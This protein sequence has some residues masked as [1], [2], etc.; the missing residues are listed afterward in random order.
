MNRIILV[1]S[2][3]LHAEAGGGSIRIWA[4]RC[5]IM[6]C[7]LDEWPRKSLSS[8]THSHDGERKLRTAQS[9]PSRRGDGQ[10]EAGTEFFFG[11]VGCQGWLPK[12]N[13]KSPEPCQRFLPGVLKPM[14]TYTLPQRAARYR[15]LSIKPSGRRQ[16]PAVSSLSPV[17]AELVDTLAAEVARLGRLYCGD[18][19]Y[20][21]LVWR[22]RLD[23]LI[24]DQ[25]PAR[26][27]AHA[28]LL[29]IYERAGAES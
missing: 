26:D 8:G 7:R 20:G 29:E 17:A 1:D 14:K 22:R 21:Y 12:R 13:K 16:T 4:T 11:R 18:L 10:S 5:E 27:K 2:D 3:Q 28:A 23:D 15:A 6:R 9:V 24:D 25:R 19:G